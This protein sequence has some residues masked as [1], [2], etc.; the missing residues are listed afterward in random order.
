VSSPPLAGAPERPRGRRSPWLGCYVISLAIHL[1]VFLAVPAG[2]FSLM[3]PRLPPRSHE[4][5]PPVTLR[6]DSW[7]ALEVVEF[8]TVD[9]GPGD[10]AVVEAAGGGSDVKEEAGEDPAAWVER[11]LGSSPSRVR[12]SGTLAG[13]SA[14][15]GEAGGYLPPVPLAVR[16][17]EYPEGAPRSRAP[18]TVVVRVHVTVEGT[19]D[20]A[21]LETP[22]E[23]DILNRKALEVARGLRFR[24][25]MREGR[26]VSDWFS[27]PVT[28]N[29][30]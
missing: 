10:A 29:R 20:G 19:V 13:P 11:L 18:I 27:F 23:S 21:V 4:P 15:G 22:A 7:H 6:A 2:T 16:W 14:S 28:F 9:G 25:A 17:P 26:P 12:G 24:P 5:G 1:G 3:G 30:R 8:E